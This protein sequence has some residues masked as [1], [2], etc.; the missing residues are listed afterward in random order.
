M[1]FRSSLLSIFRHI[2]GRAPAEK[3]RKDAS[4]VTVKRV[5]DKLSV[6]GARASE[7]LG[8]A[9]VK[10]CGLE[11]G[12]GSE[13]RSVVPGAELFWQD[14]RFGLRQLFLNPGF[15]LSALAALALGIGANSAIFSVVNTVLLKPLNYPDAD[16]MVNFLSPSSEIASDLHNIP[17]F[18]FLQRQTNLFKEVVAF[19]NAGPGFNLTGGSHPEQV[20]GIHVTE[21]YF[22]MYGAPVAVGRTFTPQDDSPHGG[23]VVVLSYGLWQRR[24]G[25]DP[26]IA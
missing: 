12:N 1:K 26:A 5:A 18:H 20:N 2:V 21:G 8:H 17:E 10:S 11:Q 22:R 14:L 6:E 16:R 25:G 15:T 23:N 7:A 9:T 24:F 19:D 3:N 13:R 4:N